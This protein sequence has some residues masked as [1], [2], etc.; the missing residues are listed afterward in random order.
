MKSMLISLLLLASAFG[1]QAL[2]QDHYFTKSGAIS[3]NAE[4]ALDDVE[5]IRAKT[6]TAT[7][8][9][10]ASTGQMEWA[11]LMKS[12]QFKN[13]LMQEHFN[14]NYVESSKFPKASFKGMIENP[15]AIKWEKDG[16]YPI[17]VNGKLTLHGVTKDISAKGVITVAK[18]AITATSD[19]VVLVGDYDIEIPSLV[20]NKV[21]KDVKVN[22]STSLSKLVK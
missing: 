22:V 7:C 3:F 10:D 9:I 20:G 8:V 17:T 18:G 14:E 16:T 13:A 2:A 4:G 19:F 12:F 15:E 21:S 1:H 6:N 11:L 5:E